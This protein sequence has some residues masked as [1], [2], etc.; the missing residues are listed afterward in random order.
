MK[1]SE[2]IFDG[3]PDVVDPIAEHRAI[4][5]CLFVGLF[6]GAAAGLI[7]LIIHF[8]NIWLT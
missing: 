5:C 8:I 7:W 2:K 6:I 4:A 1:N 3:E